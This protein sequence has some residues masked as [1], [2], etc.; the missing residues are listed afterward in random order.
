MEAQSK[1]LRQ[2]YDTFKFLL[3]KRLEN[4][5]QHELFNAKPKEILCNAINKYIS[6][7]LCF[8]FSF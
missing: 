6:I 1:N 4:K 2:T 8:L 7:G 3:K 5:L